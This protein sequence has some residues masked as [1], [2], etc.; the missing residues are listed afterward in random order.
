MKMT[1][2]A[3]LVAG[4]L[5]SA[6]AF[7]VFAHTGATGIVKERMEDMSSMAQSVKLISE[8]FK[9]GAY[10]ANI[11]VTGA[12][13]MQTHAG[14]ELTSL[15]PEGSNSAASKAKDAI[16]ADWQAFSALADELSLLSAALE[17][18]AGQPVPEGNSADMG[19]GT[20]SSDMG[21]GTS[22][23]VSDPTALAQLSAEQVF[24]LVTKTCSTC[25]T[26]FRVEK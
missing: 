7:G 8:M 9:A 10:D 4:T 15:F 25:H 19:M 21:M 1:V 17:V 12:R 23:D 24:G 13:A 6:S 2:K 16:W 20:S 22:V 11:I 18:V 14:E 3:W 5:I 26:K